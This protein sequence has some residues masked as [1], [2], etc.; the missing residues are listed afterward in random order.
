M[1]QDI[2]QRYLANTCTEEERL[3]VERWL[4]PT[5]FSQPHSSISDDHKDLQRKIW[6]D[7]SVKTRR[8]VNLPIMRLTKYSVAA[9]ILLLLTFQEND[10]LL[11]LG[12]DGHL[13]HIEKINYAMG[14]SK[15]EGLVDIHRVHNPTEEPIQITFQPSGRIYCLAENQSYI[16]VQLEQ[17]PGVIGQKELILSADQLKM[18]PDVPL[19]AYLAAAVDHENLKNKPQQYL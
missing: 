16:H 7:I 9:A 14:N 2:I 1:N 19:A 4:E 10:V 3:Q 15:A 6:A 17:D 12:R 11:S 13:L 5:E 18:L 8:Q